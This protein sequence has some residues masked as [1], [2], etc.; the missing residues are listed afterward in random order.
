MQ[1]MFQVK[2]E[3]GLLGSAINSVPQAAFW[4]CW[5]ESFSS[6]LV[7]VSQVLVKLFL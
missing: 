3:L 4:L 5:P 6:I 7:E 1:A 2:D